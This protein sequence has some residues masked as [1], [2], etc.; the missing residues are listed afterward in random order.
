[1]DMHGFYCE[2]LECCLRNKST[3]LFITAKSICK[4]T[5]LYFLLPRIMLTAVAFLSSLYFC[6]SFDL[7]IVQA[8]SDT[9]IAVQAG[10]EN[11][12]DFKIPH[13]CNCPRYHETDLA[14]RVAHQVWLL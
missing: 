11:H 10:P 5:V 8:R 14:H 7:Y 13:W 2:N 9:G 4:V 12:R 6:L 1:M 3:Y